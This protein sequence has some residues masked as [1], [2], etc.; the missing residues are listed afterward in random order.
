[1]S[2]FRPGLCDSDKAALSNDTALYLIRQAV[3]KRRSLIHGRLH[4]GKGGHC[5]VGCLWQDNPKIVLR[6][7]LI[8]EVAAVNDSVPPTATP[9]QRWKVV[10]GWLRWKVQVLRGKK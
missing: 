7:S 1:M 5:A 4:D 3:A 10:N 6:S 8:D 9:H 2:V